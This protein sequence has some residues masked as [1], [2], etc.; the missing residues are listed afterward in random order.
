MP[1]AGAC[2]L[3]AK[4]GIW[5]ARQPTAAA[6]APPLLPCL[7]AAWTW[8]LVTMFAKKQLALSESPAQS[9]VGSFTFS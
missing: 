7:S 6:T 3:P 8:T 4:F 1:F 5:P 9:P 2:G